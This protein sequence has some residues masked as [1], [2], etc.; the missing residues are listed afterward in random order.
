MSSPTGHP[1]ELGV[2]AAFEV[3]ADVVVVAASMIRHVQL[4]TRPQSQNCTQ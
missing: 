3:F 4:L 1:W 2:A